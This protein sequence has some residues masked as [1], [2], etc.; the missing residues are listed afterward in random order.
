MS[1]VLSAFA[2]WLVWVGPR[3][4]M[5]SS[6]YYLAL[7]LKSQLLTSGLTE[8]LKMTQQIRNRWS[9]AAMGGVFVCSV[10]L[11]ISAIAAA[12]HKHQP[13]TDGTSPYVT[14]SHP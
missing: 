1:M 11:L 3:S 6:L 4:P 10:L 13:D 5:W 2:F 12:A 14:F 9:V 7:A 8:N